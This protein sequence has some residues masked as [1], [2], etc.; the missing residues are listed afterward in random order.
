MSSR[1]LPYRQRLLRSKMKRLFILLG[2]LVLCFDLADCVLLGQGGFSDSPDLSQ[3][4]SIFPLPYFQHLKVFSAD[5][6]FQDVQSPG[7]ATLPDLLPDLL[8]PF[9]V[10]PV[11]PEVPPL[12]KLILFCFSA[13]S[14]GIPW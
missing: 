14:G 1:R 6:D 13:S 7:I 4:A 10:Q 9:L 3:A 12:R 8:A 5:G 2:L 11:E